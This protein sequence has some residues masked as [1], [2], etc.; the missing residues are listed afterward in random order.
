MKAY[1]FFAVILFALFFS[2]K[3]EA[4]TG[5]GLDTLTL[6]NGIRLTDYASGVSYARTWF[7]NSSAYHGIYSQWF[8]VNRNAPDLAD[9]NTYYATF[10]KVF[11]RNINVASTVPQIWIKY[12]HT[13]PLVNGYNEVVQF[14]IAFGNDGLISDFSDAGTTHD[15]NWGPI[16]LSPIPFDSIDCMYIKISGNFKKTLVQVDYF[17]FVEYLGGPVLSVIEDFEDSTIVGV[18]DEPSMPTNYSLS[19]NY[20]NPFNPET[21]IKFQI[22]TFSHVTLKI[23][24]VLGREVETLV[25]ED[26]FAGEYTVKFSGLNLASGMYLCQINVG[27]GQFVQTKKMMLVK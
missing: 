21:T 5:S 22:P 16:T 11:T 4:Q 1:T 6:V 14:S 25:N 2:F 23:F 27:N 17:T 18:E 12:M 8:E 9:V 26:R 10:K 15:G 24:D 13:K 19:Q 3:V 20:P 7:D